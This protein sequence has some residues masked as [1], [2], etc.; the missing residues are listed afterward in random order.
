MTGKPWFNSW[1]ERPYWIL[2]LF[3]LLSS[4]FL[5]LFTLG[6]RAAAEAWTWPLSFSLEV[7]NASSYAFTSPQYFMALCL[8]SHQD[9]FHFSFITNWKGSCSLGQKKS[10][11]HSESSVFEFRLDTCVGFSAHTSKNSSTLNITEI[12]SPCQI[13][14]LSRTVII[15]ITLLVFGKGGRLLYIFLLGGE[16][17]QISPHLEAQ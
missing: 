1:Q 15:M 17:G 6:G 2:G 9:N 8:I 13:Q 11:F 12:R 10:N 5:G 3:R 14:V 4:T 16:R 7:K